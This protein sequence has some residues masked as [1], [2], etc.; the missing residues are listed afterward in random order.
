MQHASTQ[1][2]KVYDSQ[3]DS[4]DDLF[5]EYDTVATV[6]LGAEQTSQKTQ[7]PDRPPSP[8]YVTQPT[9]PLRPIPDTANKT[10]DKNPSDVQVVASSPVHAP[11]S[12][13]PVAPRPPSHLGGVL[14]SSMAPAGT[15]F[16]MPMGVARAP[17]QQKVIH[18]SDDDDGPR[19]RGGSSSED[20]ADTDRRADIKP[21]TFGRSGRNVSGSD[22]DRI[23]ESPQA[24]MHKFREIMS[25]SVYDPAAKGHGSALS[26]SVFDARNRD[27]RTSST[28]AT[29]AKR[30]ADVMANS[31]G[32]A[33]PPKQARQ[34]GPSKALPIDD[35][36][37]DSIADYGMRMKIQKMRN[38]LPS[39]SVSACR[40]ALIVKRGNFDD[41]MDAIVALEERKQAVDL[42][43][44]DDELS[45]DTTTPVAKKSTARR[46]VKAP[47]RSIQ[48]KWSSTQALAKQ[49]SPQKPASTTPPKPRRKLVQGRKQ[50]SLPSSPAKEDPKPQ[51][52]RR[53]RSPSYSDDDSDS[54]V[55]ELSEEDTVTEG[56]VLKFFNTCTVKDL[57]DISNQTE[58]VAGTI[59]AQRPFSNLD[60]VRQISSETTTTTKTG[61]RRTTKKTIGDKVVDICLEMWTGY[62][63]VDELVSKCE[64]L[65]KPVA[66]EMAKWGFDVFGAA[67][68]GELS[69]T[70]MDG[71][72]D[73][74]K[75]VRDSGVG[76]PSGASSSGE[77]DGDDADV[78]IVGVGRKKNKFI[79]QPSVMPANIVMKDYQIVG[80]NW[81]A[82]LYE[83]KLSCILADEMG[84]GKTCQVISFVAHL[85]EKGITG[86]HLVVVPGSTLENWL[87][88]F[89]MFCPE[90]V[91]EPYYGAQAERIEI[92]DRI[93]SNRDKINVIVTTYDM[94]TNKI[95]SKFLRNQRPVVCVYDE[96]HLLKNSQ[97]N[98]YVQLM[99]IP[100]QFRLLLTGTPLQNNLEELA[101]LLGFILPFVFNDRS[102]DLKYIFKHKAK[103][104]DESQSHAAL[105][106]AQRIAR[107][108]SMMAPFVLRRKKH[109]VLKHLPSKTCRVEFCDLLPSQASIYSAE[110]DRVRAVMAARAAG[111]K[112]DQDSSNNNIMMQLRKAAIHPLLFRR[113]YEDSKIR[114]M[115]RECIREDKLVDSDPDIIYEEMQYMA[116]F[117]LHRLCEEYPTTLGKYA[118]QKDEWMDSG[119]VA[120]LAQLLKSYTSQPDAN[121]D[122]NRILLFSQ[123]TVVL[124]ILE[125]VLATLSLDF[126]RLDG[127][128]PI[129]ERQTMIDEF[130]ESDDIPVFMLSTK[131]G[132]SGINLACANKVI[133]FDSS[134]NPQEDIQAENRAHRVG[135]KRE[136]DVVRLVTND[137]IEVQI[138][139]LGETKLALDDRVSGYG[140]EEKEVREAETQ[141]EKEVEKM[142][143]GGSAAAKLNGDDKIT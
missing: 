48:D 96:G 114:K 3:D 107:A 105:L 1:D 79:Q 33:R 142:L 126:F 7:A 109:Q 77:L 17:P 35:I 22:L 59:L 119:K 2:S 4:G 128:T 102:E 66:E 72:K 121:G 117:Q 9:Q 130:Y 20:D 37:L 5:G 52:S 46:Q 40:N 123:F 61:K 24:G 53:P 18:L 56:K 54:G 84:L 111:E 112:L 143:F 31:Y 15:A 133:I 27:E 139:A 10:A 76:T 65:G 49:D 69:M 136:V 44:S 80:L 90:L 78:K 99:R 122:K 97:S 87:K 63:A 134:F 129:S 6:P 106:S 135:Q 8:G 45:Q 113:I 94:A 74:S 89:A 71:S 64:S 57:S 68:E 124:D 13:S 73:D 25:S 34:N 26:G 16:R 28:F 88:E 125:Q 91:V 95:D 132:G 75:S 116:D 104:K 101:S 82:L 137:T 21:S 19:Y 92:R 62:E 98:R 67:K 41:A 47:L 38:V 127:S 138:H 120:K 14:A 100:A 60:E 110:Q 83:K 50:P 36:P 55:A 32:N 43:G 58:K 11:A 70:S 103:T 12:S 51:S 140:A 141:G 131:A 93:E 85:Y 108:K 86:P 39:A 29:P 30:S 81:L 23:E 42:T 115:S 118:L